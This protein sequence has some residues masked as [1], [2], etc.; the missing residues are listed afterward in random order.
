M[1]GKGREFDFG[2]QGLERYGIWTKFMFDSGNLI[3]SEQN[4][5]IYSYM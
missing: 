3:S 5:K 1:T 2:I 4:E